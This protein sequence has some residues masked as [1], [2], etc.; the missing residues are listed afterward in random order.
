MKFRKR[1]FWNF[2]VN[3]IIQYVS[4]CN[5][6][7]SLNTMFSRFIPVEACVRISFLFMAFYAIFHCIHTHTHTHTLHFVYSFISWTLGWFQP[8]KRTFLGWTHGLGFCILDIQLSRTRRG[9]NL[10]GYNESDTHIYITRA[11]ELMLHAMISVFRSRHLS[12]PHRPGPAVCS[13]FLF[14][15]GLIPHHSSESV[16]VKGTDDLDLA[17][18]SSPFSVLICFNVSATFIQVALSPSAPSMLLLLASE[19]FP[20]SLSIA[21][22]SLAAFLRV[23]C[24]NPYWRLNLSIL[25]CHRIPLGR[26]LFCVYTSFSSPGSQH[27]LHSS[28]KLLSLT[29]TFPLD[30]KLVYSTAYWTGSLGSWPLSFFGYS[31][32]RVSL[33]FLDFITLMN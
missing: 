14:P 6:L 11:A 33:S 18:S 30:S 21:P 26:L 12:S 2:H 17:K 4:F 32:V 20:C 23:L 13:S 5:W 29:M 24:G 31:A 7:I 1:F 27:H 22:T 9:K 25:Q 3:E 10:S 15:S 8:S 28:P 16:F 19:N